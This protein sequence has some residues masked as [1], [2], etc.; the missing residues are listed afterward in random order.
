MGYASQMRLARC[1]MPWRIFAAA[2]AGIIAGVGVARAD[3]AADERAIGER[4]ERWTAA[5][6]ARDAVGACDLFAPDLVYALPGLVDATYE[7]MCGNL[8][9]ALA[10]PNLTMTYAQPD[11]H[12]IL[13]DGDLAVVRLTW[14]LTATAGGRTDTTSDEGLD[15]FR[16]QADGRWSIVRFLAFPVRENRVLE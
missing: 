4:L 10:D 12:E 1:W 14:T 15:V 13:V 6:N 2:L 8:T 3:T 7:R 16:R 11:I 9:K 5:F